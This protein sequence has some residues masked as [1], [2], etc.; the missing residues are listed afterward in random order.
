[1]IDSSDDAIQLELIPNNF[2]CVTVIA[3]VV[4]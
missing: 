3:L 1:M 2:V 4:V